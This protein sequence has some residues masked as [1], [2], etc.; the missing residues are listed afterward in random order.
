MTKI[1]LTGK[2]INDIFKLP[3]LRIII[4]KD[5]QKHI[6]GFNT[7]DGDMQTLIERLKAI[8]HTRIQYPTLKK[9]IEQKEK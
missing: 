3:S 2:N 8:Y 1:T 6:F 4:K 9:E 7:V 5:D